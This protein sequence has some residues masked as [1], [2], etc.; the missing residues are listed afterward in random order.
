MKIIE[1]S[2]SLPKDKYF[3]K[4]LSIINPLLPIQLTNKEIEIIASFLSVETEIGSEN[5]FSTLGKE[6]VR[7]SLKLSHA[8]LS[9]YIKN[10]K[11]KKVITGTDNNLKI[12]DVLRPND[13]IQGYR[14]KL[15]IEK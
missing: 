12:I 9:N 4:H 1:K 15:S 13:K 14:I 3:E 11:E 2:L 10:L 5:I 7:N 6:K 8:G